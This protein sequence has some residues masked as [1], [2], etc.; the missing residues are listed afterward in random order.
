MTYEKDFDLLLDAVRDTLKDNSRLKTLEEVKQSR[1]ETAIL[2]S[3]QSMDLEGLANTFLDS[4]FNPKSHHAQLEN[5]HTLMMF[6][7][8]SWDNAAIL[9]GNLK[10][11]GIEAHIENERPQY[12]NWSP[13]SGA[14][15]VVVDPT[16][17][18]FI[19]NLVYWSSVPTLNG[20]IDAV[21]VNGDFSKTLQEVGPEVVHGVVKQLVDKHIYESTNPRYGHSLLQD[22]HTLANT[23]RQR[24]AESRAEDVYLQAEVAEKKAAL[25]AAIEASPHSRRIQE[26]RGETARI[27]EDIAHALPL[28]RIEKFISGRL[29]QSRVNE[30]IDSI[31]SDAKAGT[32]T[33]IVT[34]VADTARDE[35]LAVLEDMGIPKEMAK[36]EWKDSQVP[37]LARTRH[38][39][40]VTVD[41]TDPD[42]L[43]GMISAEITT[44]LRQMPA[45]ADNHA[46]LNERVT[47]KVLEDVLGPSKE[48]AAAAVAATR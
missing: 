38:T 8:Q 3:L 41:F 4:H 33:I 24:H 10:E 13:R 1:D 12:S 16:Q 17:P 19:E 26:I 9:V 15:A 40:T 28:G 43:E 30:K 36:A 20:M 14:A 44:R 31:T 35:L 29:R 45:D 48:V 23:R 21:K 11:F 2:A 34:G 22:L 42:V 39:H 46:R 5:A 27:G 7:H 32:L 18:E 37:F 25:D 6:N 47:Q